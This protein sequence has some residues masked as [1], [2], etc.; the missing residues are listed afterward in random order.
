MWF[1]LRC[2]CEEKERGGEVG[3]EVRGYERK[4]MRRGRKGGVRV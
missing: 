1:R 3:R 2:V 4:C